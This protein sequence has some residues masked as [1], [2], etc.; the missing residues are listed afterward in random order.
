[1]PTQGREKNEATKLSIQYILSKELLDGEGVLLQHL[2]H[3]TGYKSLLI[4]LVR[5]NSSTTMVF[6]PN[7][8]QQRVV[9]PCHIRS[10]QSDTSE[11]GEQ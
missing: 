9:V 8:F 6:A 4:P 7:V 5:A 10:Y 2:D 3:R 11:Y 1:M